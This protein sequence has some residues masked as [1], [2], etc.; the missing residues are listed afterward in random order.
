LIQI[1]AFHIDMN[2]DLVVSAL[3]GL[4]RMVSRRLLRSFALVM[5][6]AATSQRMAAVPAKAPGASRLSLSEPFA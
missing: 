1:G 3:M 4:F 2:I 5:A 6:G